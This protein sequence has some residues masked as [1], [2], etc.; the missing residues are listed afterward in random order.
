MKY[1]GLEE[2][3]FEEKSPSVWREWIEMKLISFQHSGYQSPSVWREWIEITAELER[4][5]YIWS[6]SVWR[7]WI[8]IALKMNF[9]RGTNSLPPCGGSGLKWYESYGTNY[10]NCLPPCGGSGLK[11]FSPVKINAF[12]SLPP[13]GGS[14]LKFQHGE[15]GENCDVSPSVWREWIEM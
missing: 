4:L 9:S 10:R 12:R 14:G 13:C 7:E 5:R 3:T 6:P 15:R 8:E 11:C 2:I 1:S